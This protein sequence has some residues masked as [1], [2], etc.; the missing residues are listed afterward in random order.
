MRFQ[1]QFDL[2]DQGQGPVFELVQDLYVINTWFKFEDKIQNPQKLSC[3]QGITQTTQPTTTTTEPKQY[4]SPGLGGRHNYAPK[5][6]FSNFST[7]PLKKTGGGT[8]YYAR[9]LSKYRPS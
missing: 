2:E 4:V 1:G 6:I 9:R 5:T 8:L 3:S 7:N